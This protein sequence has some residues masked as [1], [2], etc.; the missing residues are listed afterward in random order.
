M[1]MVFILR[2][3]A[4]YRFF[5][6]TVRELCRAG[7]SVKVLLD[8]R[9]KGSGDAVKDSPRALEAC[10]ADLPNFSWGWAI[11]RDDVWRKWIFAIRELI[12]YSSYLGPGRQ[13]SRKVSTRYKKHLPGLLEGL[14]E[15][16]S[17]RAW[18]NRPIVQRALRLFERLIPAD[19]RI[20]RWLREHRPDIVIASPVILEHSEEV[21]Y[22]KSALALRIPNVLAVLSWDHLT[23]KGV[24]QFVPDLT[25]VWNKIQLDEA[26]RYHRVPPQKVAFTGA[27]A[28]DEWFTM[29]PTQ[30][31]TTFCQQAGLDP[32]RRFALYLCSSRTIA[33]DE[34]ALV[35]AVAGALREH[36]ATRR[37]QL[38]VRPYPWN[39][40][41]WWRYTNE[42][43]TIWPREDLNPDTPEA[44]Q[45]F[46]H[47]LHFSSAVI[48]INTSALIDAAI[49]DR[50]CLT[51]LT[52]QYRDTQQDVSH[53]RHLL[54]ADFLE[55]ATD[56]PQ[57]AEYVSAI[58][59]GR[60]A[61]REERR[62]F[63]REFI[64]PWGVEQPASQVMARVIEAAARRQT[65]DQ[66]R[67]T[68][69][70]N[71]QPIAVSSATP[72]A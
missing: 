41:I 24:I 13:T 71:G 27:P 51:L 69:R 1:K 36:A 53:F 44:R 31:R 54:E 42:F 7:H 23:T 63:V 34:T 2:H 9:H 43:F 55:V 46:W 6:S 47:A 12:N 67:L 40:E 37:V 32:D 30:D 72:G 3:V 48:G 28:F 22:L 14:V 64:R 8:P 26:V 19:A 39:T 62:R 35:E 20:S 59:G 58:L 60:D 49:A 16:R 15:H 21:E 66:M 70:T 17:V 29:Q 57:V 11:N 4:Y 56:L 52:E 45:D 61:K 50:P 25:L 10:A 5:D 65:V 18:L 68:L 38:L 33:E